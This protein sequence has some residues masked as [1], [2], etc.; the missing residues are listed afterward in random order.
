MQFGVMFFS[1]SDQQGEKDKYFLLKEA[2]RFA[3]TH[4]F[5]SI[6]TPERHFHEF[7]GLFPNPA[8][9]SAAIAMVTNKIQIRAGS[10]ISPLHDP[11]RIAEEWAMVDNL[12]AGRVA[13][14][15]GSGWNV[16]DFVFFPDRY[17]SRS[18]LM[19]EQISDVQQLWQGFSLGRKNGVAREMQIQIFPR[20]IQPVLPVWI[21]T[22]GNPESFARI[23]CHGS[24]LL[25]HLL[26]QDL[27][28]LTDHI[29]V[30]REARRSAG[31]DP[32]SGIVSLLLHSFVG[33]DLETIKKMVKVPLREYLRS[34]VRLEKQSAAA[35][36]KISGNSEA[37]ADSMP[38]ADMEALLDISFD[39]YFEHGSLLGTP[40][41]CRSMV[42]KLER[43][44]VNE[45]ACLIDFGVE[46]A[47][48]LE[49]LELIAGLGD[50]N[51]QIQ[52][53]TLLSQI[54]QFNQVLT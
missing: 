48:V 2:A 26:G 40:E 30:Y 18:D 42:R 3:D 32:Q 36:G 44:G 4:G 17:Q 5:N 28:S 49:S 38:S 10:L 16:N 47:Q 39:R 51:S 41:K 34:A 33:N 12:S 19:Y 50:S 7:G 11:V 22:S 23:G 35:G 31:F 52:D 54:E 43:C 8:I 27:D 53:E 46:P 13:I 24:N 14:S 20:P 1:S 29:S 9:T 6:W 37:S 45:I 15:F 25:T 21:T